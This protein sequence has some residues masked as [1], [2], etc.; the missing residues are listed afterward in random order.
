[1][2]AK[3]VMLNDWVQFSGRPYQV[4]L[5]DRYCQEHPGSFC[6]IGLYAEDKDGA[7]IKTPTYPGAVHPI[8]LTG[9]IL[10]QNGFKYES[11][12]QDKDRWKWEDE[13]GKHYI[14]YDI[15]VGDYEITL[16]GEN[17]RLELYQNYYQ[18]CQPITVHQLQQLIRLA[19]INKEITI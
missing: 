12:T 13:N 9:E 15:L 6:G 4:C 17:G 18:G 1:M 11:L 7:F 2:N 19:G 3:E 14:I 8:D 5:I 10:E 16:N